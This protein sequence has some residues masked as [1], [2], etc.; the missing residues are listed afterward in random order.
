VTRNQVDAA[1]RNRTGVVHWCIQVVSDGSFAQ[2]WT[3]DYRLLGS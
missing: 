1:R 3:Y 2:F